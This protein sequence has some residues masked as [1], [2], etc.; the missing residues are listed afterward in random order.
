MLK[1]VYM[2]SIF[3]GVSQCLQ[4]LSFET[5]SA[6]KSLVGYMPLRREY[7]Q[8]IMAS[9]SVYVAVIGRR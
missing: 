2:D 5:S 9:K 7:S 4:R 1:A 6:A 8:R 3:G